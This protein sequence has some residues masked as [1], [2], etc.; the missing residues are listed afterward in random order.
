MKLLEDESDFLGAEAREAGFVEARDVGAINDGPAGRGS[1][2]AAENID[3]RG[4]ARAGR[5]HDGD[6]FAGLDA[7]RDAVE[8]A[9]VAE[10]FAD[11]FDLDDRFGHMPF[12][13][14]DSKSRA[15]ASL[16]PAPAKSALPSSGQ[17]GRQK[18]AGLHSG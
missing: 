12:S 16:R 11:I 18:R 2:E 15:D 17:A 14:G 10:L 7:E 4:L 1:I 6:P 3:Q 13:Q 5:A 9:D 8:R